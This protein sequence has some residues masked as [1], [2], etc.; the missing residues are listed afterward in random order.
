MHRNCG[1]CWQAYEEALA[2]AWKWS[3]WKSISSNLDEQK[4]QTTCWWPANV[5]DRDNLDTLLV[6]GSGYRI[7]AISNIQTSISDASRIWLRMLMLDTGRTQIKD[8][9]IWMIEANRKTAMICRESR[10]CGEGSSVCSWPPALIQVANTKAVTCRASMPSTHETHGA[11]ACCI[12][13][14]IGQWWNSWRYPSP[15]PTQ[16]TFHTPAREP[17]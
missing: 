15:P 10:R 11:V 13:W 3:C 12:T 14:T 9:E 17:A 4:Q 8:P 2:S 6:Q 7:A 1:H 5:C 16:S